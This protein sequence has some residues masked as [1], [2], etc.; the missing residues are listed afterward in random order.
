MRFADLAI[1]DRFDWVNGARP[2]FCHFHD[3]CMKTGP[4]K[5]R[6]IETAE[7]FRVGT[8]NAEVHHVDLRKS[9]HN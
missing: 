9:A 8:V 1:G 7:E 6:S 2:T 5:Y 4:R 3:R